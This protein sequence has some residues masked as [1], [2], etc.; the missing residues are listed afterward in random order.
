MRKS[1]LYIKLSLLAL[2]LGLWTNANA[3]IIEVESIKCPGE[4]NGQ[5]NVNIT[6]ST[7]DLNTYSWE[8]TANP[9]L[10]IG[11]EKTLKG[12]GAGTY[13]VQVTDGITNP[14]FTYTINEPA[15]IA[16]SFTTNANS[17]WPNNNGTINMTSSTGGSGWLEYTVKD[18]ISRE[19]LPTKGPIFTGLASGAYFVKA[20]D[21]NGC[22]KDTVVRVAESAT[23]AYGEIG[24]NYDGKINP[25][26]TACY[27]FTTSLS[28][29]PD[30]LGIQFPVTVMMD[31][32][33]FK[34]LKGY[35]RLNDSTKMHTGLGAS[36]PVVK[37]KPVGP[38]SF[39]EDVFT[40]PSGPNAGQDS[41]KLGSVSNTFHP[42]FHIIHIYT[43]DGRGFRYSWDVDSVVA[44]I[45]I[46]YVQTNNVCF[47]DKKGSFTATAQG[48]YQ[49]FAKKYLYTVTVPTGQT[50]IAPTPA[51]GALSISGSNLMAGRYAVT[52]TDPNDVA[53]CPVTQVINIT[54][55]DE[56]LRIVFENESNTTC[57]NGTNGTV[58]VLRVDGAKYPMQYY[59]WNTLDSIQTLSNL[60]IG[61]YVVSVSDANGCKAKDSTY[62]NA[63]DRILNIVWDPIIN[64]RCPYSSEGALSIRGINGAEY[65]VSYEWSTGDT[66]QTLENLKP[67]K[68]LVTVTDANKC[69]VSDSVE[70][71]SLNKS[72]FYNII[73][74]NGDGYNDYFD[75]SDLS[76]E[77]KLECK[78]FNEAGNLIATLDETNP[79]WDGLNQ[80]TPP[81]GSAST[82]TAFVKIT[83]DGKTIAEFG[84]SFS[85]IYT[86]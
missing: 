2:V 41:V 31:N 50:P 62:I 32:V 55:P 29:N 64:T 18:S 9:G 35:K 17:S 33:V 80:S 81:T 46:T 21:V 10:V 47:G 86:K 68:Y 85:V 61:K 20:Y 59:A 27:K 82:Y 45:S 76:R 7:P 25:D 19:I 16:I 11:T 57:S 1:T 69:L 77:V 39:I 34:V 43:N 58:G 26:T 13:Q 73:T 60:G 14:I 75:L 15:P 72:C 24:K 63:N 37:I 49:Q 42:G 23:S 52:A 44:P 83:K 71:E 70:V 74:P 54:E 30:T 67:G 53:P 12:L 79:K 4:K 28:L 36:Q 65:P 5:L 8:N 6:T 38:F 84:E 78:I 56:P 66:T 40:V 48:S 3:Q 22:K 51:A